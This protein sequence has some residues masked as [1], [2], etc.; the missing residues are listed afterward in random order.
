MTDDQQL[1]R[2]FVVA[3]ILL[4]AL[5]LGNYIHNQIKLHQYEQNFRHNSYQPLRG[6]Q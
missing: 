5:W 6:N 3:V 2:L 1:K 4:A